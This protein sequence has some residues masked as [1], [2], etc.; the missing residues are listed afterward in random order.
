MGWAGN[1]VDSVPKWLIKSLKKLLRMQDNFFNSYESENLLC[2][3]M[4]NT[5]TK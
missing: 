2:K 3:N 4:C 1:R 5:P